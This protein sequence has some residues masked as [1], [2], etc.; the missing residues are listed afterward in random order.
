M[1]IVF[2]IFKRLKEWDY[3]L[4]KLN[5]DVFIFLFNWPILLAIVKPLGC[6]QV[7]TLESLNLI[8]LIK[9]VG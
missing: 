3:L 6:L 9:C 8:I 7:K 4:N 5:A 2:C 1:R